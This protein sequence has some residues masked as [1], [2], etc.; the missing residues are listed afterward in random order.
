[1]DFSCGH[2]VINIKRT[3]APATTSVRGPRPWWLG[4]EALVQ[5]RHGVALTRVGIDPTA[6]LR[7][8]TGGYLLTPL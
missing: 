7:L 5:I 6:S 1:M 8:G 3:V 4:A 2:P